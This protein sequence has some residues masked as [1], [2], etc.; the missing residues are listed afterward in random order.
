MPNETP[1]S[2]IQ[3]W[4]GVNFSEQVGTCFPRAD[5]R[6]RGCRDP[7]QKK[8]SQLGSLCLIYPWIGFLLDRQL[9]AN[10]TETIAEEN[11]NDDHLIELPSFSK[12][13]NTTCLA[14]QARAAWFITRLLRPFSGW[15]TPSARDTISLLPPSTI[16]PLEKWKRV[17]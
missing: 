3:T 8:H 14:L 7:N 4:A 1:M 6:T 16:S 2:H 12:P 13:S 10:V 17:L 9:A 15:L 11:I 5:Q